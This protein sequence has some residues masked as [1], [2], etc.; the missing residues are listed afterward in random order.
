MTPYD[1]LKELSAGWRW[2]LAFDGAEYAL[3]MQDKD[4]PERAPITYTSADLDRLINHAW[5]GA[6]AGRC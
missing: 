4:R 5:A 2:A 1:R 3:T 6:P